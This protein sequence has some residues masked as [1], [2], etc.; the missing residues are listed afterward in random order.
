L[1]QCGLVGVEIP[2]KLNKADK[3]VWFFPAAE[4]SVITLAS[5]VIIPD[6]ARSILFTETHDSQY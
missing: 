2:E 4:V 6:D 5:F 1:P 3:T